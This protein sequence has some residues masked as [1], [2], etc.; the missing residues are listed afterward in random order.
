[1]SNVLV[2]D[3]NSIHSQ[4][5]AYLLRRIGIDFFI[6]HSEFYASPSACSLGVETV[7]DHKYLPDHETFGILPTYRIGKFRHIFLKIF[8]NALRNRLAKNQSK[9]LLEYLNSKI[10]TSLFP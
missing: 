1:M 10:V 7:I 4:K 8:R 6:F 3:M 5:F 9:K 2:A